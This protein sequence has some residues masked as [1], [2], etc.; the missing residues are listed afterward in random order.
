MRPPPKKRD[1]RPAATGTG[2]NRAAA[3][4][5]YPP[6]TR[7]LCVSLVREVERRMASAWAARS[8]VQ[9]G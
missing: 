8:V 6:N 5:L 3:T 7:F 1:A 4:Q 2:V 9:H